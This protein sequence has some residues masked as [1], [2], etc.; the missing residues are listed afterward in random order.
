LVARGSTESVFLN[1]PFD[2]Q[3]K[4]LQNAILFTIIDCGFKPRSAN[5]DE[6]G[7]EPRISKI[8]RLISDCRYAIHDLSRT[9][10]DQNG[11]PRFNMPLELGLFL[12]AQHYGAKR[13][14][15]KECLVLTKERYEHQQY[16][17][18]IAGIDV[19]PHG[20][21]V[22][23]VIKV[24]RDW[25]RTKTTHSIPTHSIIRGH[26]EQFKKGLPLYC[27]GLIPELDSNELTYNDYIA[28][29]G[30][31]LEKYGYKTTLTS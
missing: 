23:R 8:Y 16:I 25:L 18:D 26:Y 24:T 5:E 4:E 14:R 21:D 9:Q 3:Y 7:T 17:S 2:D 15:T 11:F 12:G 31:W 19:S 28:V 30:G 20:N 22:S 29:I 1:C 27:Q 13:H 6:S 10:I